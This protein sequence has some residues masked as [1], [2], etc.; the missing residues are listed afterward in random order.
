MTYSA[1]PSEPSE[2]QDQLT[3]LVA[4]R[5]FTHFAA[6]ER[7][8]REQFSDV[9]GVRLGVPSARARPTLALREVYPEGLTAERIDEVSQDL[10]RM[11]TQMPIWTITGAS[12]S[13]HLPD[14]H[15]PIEYGPLHW[16]D[17]HVLKRTRSAQK[18]E[19]CSEALSR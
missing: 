1:V 5:A 10:E 17:T 4:R 3:N 13:T 14:Y 19:E 7:L 11:R 2:N 9:A 8:S 6:R 15:I 16:R 18:H 12:A